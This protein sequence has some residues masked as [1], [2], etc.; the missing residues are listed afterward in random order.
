[1]M[2]NLRNLRLF[3]SR[4]IKAHH[5]SRAALIAGGIGAA[6]VF[7]VVGALIRLLVGPISLGPLGSALPNALAQA[8]P[9]I[10]VRYDQAAIAWSRDEGRVNLVILGARVFDAENRIIAQA[11]EA[12][13]DLAAGPLFLHGKAV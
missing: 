10:T 11:P 6:V 8:L 2:A 7:F 9:G 4:Y 1:M 5:I 13:I 3:I 12:D